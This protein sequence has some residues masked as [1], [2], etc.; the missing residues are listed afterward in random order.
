VILIGSAEMLW[1]G[2][3]RIFLLAWEL[4]F[5]AAAGAQALRAC[6]QAHGILLGC[7]ARLQLLSERLY[8]YTLAREF[9]I[10]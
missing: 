10:D 3:K 9:S 2:A 7:V 6:A 1:V 8:S 4:L 5:A